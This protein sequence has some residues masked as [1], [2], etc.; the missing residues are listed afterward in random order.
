MTE[1]PSVSTNLALAPPLGDWAGPALGG[2]AAVLAAAAL[3]VA[4]GADRR[5]RNQRER[6]RRLEPALK[7]IVATRRLVFESQVRQRLTD[8]G[9]TPRLP[10]QFTSQVGEDEFL[11]E[12]FGGQLDGR[13]L[14]VGAYDGQQL[15]VSYPFEAAGW[16]G[17]LIEPLAERA[18]QCRARRPGS[19]VVQAACGR[20]GSTGTVRFEEDLSAGMLSRVHV[21]GS[22]D[23]GSGRRTV[24]VPL[25]TVDAVLM[26]G[27]LP[28]D[29][30]VVDVEGAEEALMDGFD[31]ARARPRALLLE[32]S[33][34]PDPPGRN[35]HLIP[36]IE[37]QG[38][39]HA[40]TLEFNFVF[41][42]AAEPA[43]LERAR[44]LLAARREALPAHRHG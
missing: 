5:S 29:F 35:A 2:G 39:T 40:G 27:D 41:V 4:V 44:M 6:L 42:S 23:P 20:R 33:A 19:R 8:A 31:L 10:L 37:A 15:S 21:A 14:E 30:A 26:E 11:W 3:V 7:H 25:T 36:R 24:D 38:M 17:V 43:L 34:W 32:D 18:A 22:T 28:L 9:R 16:T 13:F 1:L 12:L